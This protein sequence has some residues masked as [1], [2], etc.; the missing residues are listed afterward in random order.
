M[1][2]GVYLKASTHPID[3]YLSN[4]HDRVYLTTRLTD[5]DD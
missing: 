5:R 4:P 1:R 3:V 2:T